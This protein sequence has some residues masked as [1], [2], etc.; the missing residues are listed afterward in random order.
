MAWRY[1]SLTFSMIATHCHNFSNDLNNN[2]VL[3][4]IFFFASGGG[5][6]GRSP[7]TLNLLQITSIFIIF[8]RKHFHG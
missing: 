8:A 2:E 5:G 1:V 7:F 3:T 4:T 6:R